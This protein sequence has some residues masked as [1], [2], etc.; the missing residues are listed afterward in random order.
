MIHG[1]CCGGEVWARLSG[2]LRETGW[3]VETPTICAQ[4]RSVSKPQ[5]SL[6]GLTLADYVEDMAAIARRLKAETGRSPVIFGHSLGGL[7]AQKLAEQRLARATVLLAPA[8][9]AKIYGIA[10]APFFTFANIFFAQ[11]F[12]TCAVKIWR[13]GFE[14]GMLNC[15]PPSRYAEIY[16]TTRFCSGL[17]LY[18]AIRPSRDPRRT[19]EIDETR[20]V[21]PVLTIGAAMDRAISVELH[22]KVGEKYKRI[23]GDYLE[24]SNNGHWILDEPGTDEVIEA[25]RTWLDNRVGRDEDKHSRDGAFQDGGQMQ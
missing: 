11:R 16:A 20:I 13:R 23:G 9:P 18:N 22:R 14:W 17:A 25:I 8:P 19:A 1:L 10:L 4:D 7:I 5:A 3:Q 15:V 12:K 2:S 6:A 21:G 24:F